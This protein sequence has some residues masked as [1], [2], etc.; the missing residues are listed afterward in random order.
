MGEDR[1]TVTKHFKNDEKYLD[2]QHFIYGNEKLVTN[3]RAGSHQLPFSF[4]LPENLPSPYESKIGHVRYFIKASICWAGNKKLF[5]H[6]KNFFTIVGL[7]DLNKKST[8]S[9]S[10][11]SL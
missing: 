4:K 10:L 11:F 8:A 2:L 6:V 9:V 7:V 1:Q 3:L 5:H